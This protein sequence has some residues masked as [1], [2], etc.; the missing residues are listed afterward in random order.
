MSVSQMTTILI[1]FP[2]CYAFI[3]HKELMFCWQFAD[4]GY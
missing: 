2:H 1:N 3:G 4:P